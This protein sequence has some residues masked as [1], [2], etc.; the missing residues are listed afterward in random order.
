MRNREHVRAC[1]CAW[2]R[3]G[4]AREEEEKKKFIYNKNLHIIF[5]HSEAHDFCSPAAASA[6]QVCAVLVSGFSQA[7]KSP[8]IS[9]RSVN[10]GAAVEACTRLWAKDMP[11]C[12]RLFQRALHFM[13]NFMPARLRF[14]E[15]GGALMRNVARVL[16]ISEEPRKCWVHT[17]CQ[18]LCYLS[19]VNL[20]D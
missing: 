19:T 6:E 1:A 3:E 9:Q 12:S 15:P 20:S 8:H 2:V 11:V 5:R 13:P 16:K 7:G 10:G 18:F 17:V 14:S 4:K